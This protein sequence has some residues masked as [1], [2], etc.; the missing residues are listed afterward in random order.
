MSSFKVLF[1]GTGTSTGVP[2]I[3]CD[4]P[5]CESENPR[6]RRL[7]SSIYLSAGELKI[8]VDT[9]PDFR[10]QALC[11]NV[12]RV[13]NL[14]ITHAHVDHLFGLDDIRRINT[15]QRASIP[16]WSSPEAIGDIR[17]IFSYVF[18]DS[19]PGTYRPKLETKILEGQLVLDD[20]G[21]SQLVVTPIDVVHG[22]TRTFG[23]RF[24][25]NGKRF[26]YIPDC[27]ELPEASI[28][29]L[30][31]LDCLVLDACKYT[32]HPTHFSVEEAVRAITMLS[33]RRAFLTHISHSI[34]HEALEQK[35]L[36][37]GLGYIKPAY[38][39]L[40]IEI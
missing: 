27:H 18:V 8:L 30:K 15:I 22:W 37:N 14:L 40:K 7:R 20:H 26:A 16:V 13:D 33:P 34:E 10:E 32:E 24:D 6:N 5:V 4:C 1:L 31:N 12:R 38:D 28:E 36:Q 21:G 25:Y 17:R 3:G 11:H 19:V 23:Y 9:S 2:M 39:G 29:Q 35:L